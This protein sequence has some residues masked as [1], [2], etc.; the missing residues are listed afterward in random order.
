MEQSKRSVDILNIPRLSDNLRPRS[1]NSPCG[2][3]SEPHLVDIPKLTSLEP[4]LSEIK[5][6]VSAPSKEMCFKLS[7]VSE[8]KAGILF[9]PSA[10]T[11]TSS[12][13]RRYVRAP[14][15]EV[16]T[17]TSMMLADNI[18][19]KNVHHYGENKID[20]TSNETIWAARQ[21]ELWAGIARLQRQMAE[22]DKSRV[23]SIEDRMSR[24][25]MK[26]GVL[27]DRIRRVEKQF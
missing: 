22:R 13:I 24:I 10:A 26:L 5:F 1:P 27:M 16:G 14:V 19:T 23:S 2:I 15:L 3:V 4:D 20:R 21:S 9:A 18:Q 25:S 17:A 11:A 8:G 12:G 7:E 6:H